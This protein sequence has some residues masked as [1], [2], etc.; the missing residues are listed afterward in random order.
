[1]KRVMLSWV[2]LV[3]S[4]ALAGEVGLKQLLDAADKNNVD[5]RIMAEQVRKARADTEQTWSALAPTLMTQGVWTH[6]QMEVALDLAAS[7]NPLLQ[8][9]QQVFVMKP[10]IPSIPDISGKA[11]VITPLNQLDAIFRLD[12]PLVDTTR[13]MRI[14]AQGIAEE[15]AVEKENLTRDVVKRQVVGGWYAYAAALAL[16]DSAKRTAE[17]SVKQ[18]ELT[19]IRGKVGVVTELDM[20]RSR[21]EV[22]RTKQMVADTNTL[23]NTTRRMLTTLA[24]LEPPELA[25]LP[26]DD[27][28]DE[29]PLAELEPRIEGL[30]AIHAAD[31]DAEAAR[32]ISE[33]AKLVLVPTVT[34]NFQERLTNAT[35]FSGRVGHLVDGRGPRVARRPAGLLHD[36]GAR[37]GHQHRGPGRREGAQPGQGPA[38]QRPAEAR[39]RAHQ[40]RGGQGAGAGGSACSAGGEGP[41]RRRRRHAGRRHPG[42]ARPVLGGGGADLR[43]HRPRRGAGLDAH[44]GRPAAGRGV[45]GLFRTRRGGSTAS[46]VQIPNLRAARPRPRRRSRCR[47]RRPRRSVGVSRAHFDF[48]Q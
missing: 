20:L 32:V 28:S 5:R 27:L 12:L 44:L 23:V 39:R 48:A 18:M 19:E 37:G 15:S 14:K 36:Q 33:S 17:V 40:G 45:G 24:G 42:R 13:W 25:Q 38:L 22:E 4:A 1:M 29:A 26:A 16:R 31:K 9:M 10:G 2:V 3:S 47:C 46:P 21:A 41:V 30:P 34:A 6:N 11:S 35:G 8:V 7:M 43:A